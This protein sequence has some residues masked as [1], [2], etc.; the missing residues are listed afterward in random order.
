VHL[1]QI[2]QTYVRRTSFFRSGIS[3]VIGLFSDF[4]PFLRRVVK[5]PLRITPVCYFGPRWPR[6]SVARHGTR[7]SLAQ[8]KGGA[9]LHSRSKQATNEKPRPEGSSRRGE[10]THHLAHPCRKRQM[11]R[12][13]GLVRKEQILLFGT[14][15]RFPRV[16]AVEPS[17]F[18][19]VGA[20]RS[21]LR[22]TP[23]D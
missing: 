15:L 12:I 23:H 2:S 8:P 10:E 19:P 21:S 14:V 6:W 17:A 4:A 16:A 1:F 22:R 3:L 9:V 11:D 7:L 18:V 20:S 13:T 5:E